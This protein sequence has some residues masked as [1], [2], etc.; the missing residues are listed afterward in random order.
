MYNNLTDGV[1]GN[2]LLYKSNN[3]TTTRESCAALHQSD[4]EIILAVSFLTIFIL[5]AYKFVKSFSYLTWADKIPP[6]VLVAQGN[7]HQVQQ[8]KSLLC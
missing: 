4:R 2:T 1:H 3:T 7:V 6:W 8:V 5:G